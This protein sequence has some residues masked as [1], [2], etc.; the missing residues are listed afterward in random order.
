MTLHD[1]YTTR[2]ESTQLMPK[3]RNTRPTQSPLRTAL[4]GCLFLLTVGAISVFAFVLIA[5]PVLFRQFLSPEYQ[6]KLARHVPFVVAWVP[7]RAYTADTLPTADSSRADAALALLNDPTSTPLVLPTTL[8]P[9]AQAVDVQ[10]AQSSIPTKTSS[11][12]PPPTNT[13]AASLAAPTDRPAAVAVVS[14]P[15]VEI[16]TA[17][18]ISASSPTVVPPTLV[19][20]TAAPTIASTTVPTVSLPTEL[21]PPPVSFHLTQYSWIPQTWNNCGP[22]NLTQVLNHY[23]L[24]TTQKQVAAWLKPNVNDANVSPWQLVAYVNKFSSYH[25]LQRANGSLDLL[26]RLM[27]AQFSTIIETGFT[28]PDNPKEGWMGHY[29]T[30]IGYDDAKQVVYGL[31]SYLGAGPDQLG[32]REQY[33]DLDERWSHFNRVYVVI[34]PPEREDEVRAILGTDADT[35]VNAQN[36]L[37]K[38]RQEAQA[39]QSNAFAWFNMGTSYVML[40]DYKQAAVAYDKARTVGSGLPWRMLWYQFGPFSAYYNIG[41]Y[42]TATQLI[43]VTQ[44]TTVNIEEITY[45]HGMVAAAQGK[46]QQAIVDFKN[47]LA[48]NPNYTPAADA[49]AAVKSGSTPTP[50]EMP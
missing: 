5:G 12:A 26:K 20:A 10:P 43:A 46:T 15:T 33:P 1:D 7:T 35:A 31:D 37:E 36:A 41:D 16:P 8:Q 3:L 11:P 50:P 6:D 44:G 42:K 45:W 27:A 48:F 32:R 19:V 22:A 21:P 2:S 14:T 25:A 9:P 38:A 39:N 49:L 28:L 30:P 17:T 29:L 18:M 4:P 23:G 24:N 34:Y 47:A 40:H 13:S